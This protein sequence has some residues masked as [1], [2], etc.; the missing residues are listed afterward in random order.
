MKVSL[1]YIP[2]TPCFFQTTTKIQIVS[3]RNKGRKRFITPKEDG[4]AAIED[5]IQ[6][7]VHNKISKP[8]R[9]TRVADVQFVHATRKYRQIGV[10]V[11]SFFFGFISLSTRNANFGTGRL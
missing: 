3:E 11:E 1:L 7:M 6:M 10:A 9:I 8:Y 2:L 5:D 4:G